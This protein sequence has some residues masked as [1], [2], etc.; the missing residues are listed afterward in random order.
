MRTLLL[1]GTIVLFMTVQN[2]AQMGI[3][4]DNTH[5]DGSAMLDVKST[6]KGLL[7]PRLTQEQIQTITNPVNSLLVF[8]TTDDKFYA[9]LTASSQWKEVLFGTGALTPTCGTPVTDVRDG[10]SYNTVQIGTQCWM[11]QNLNIGTRINYNQNQG[12]NATIEKFCYNNLESNC[13]LFGGL[14]QWEEMMQYTTTPGAQ[15]ICPA[16]WHLPTDA[17]LT[18]LTTYLGGIGVAG[19]KMKET[20]TAHWTSPNAGATNESGFSALPGGFR[21]YIGGMG[22]LYDRSSI[23]SSTINGGAGYDCSWN[24]DLY[25]N[26]DDV[27]RQGG[28][29]WVNGFSVRC[30]KD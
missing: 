20:G 27:D 26:H 11:S 2:F 5:P 9:Y 7:I 21:N 15:G 30:V 16:D 3:N 12:N 13:D 22:L 24:V 6:S 28:A 14:Y 8:C 23:W 1:V 10:K 19:G 17:E 4:A 25:Y 18:T 29:M